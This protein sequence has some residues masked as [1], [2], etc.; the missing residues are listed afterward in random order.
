MDV[1]IDVEDENGRKLDDEEVIDV[2]LMS[3]NAGHES[4][5]HITMCATNFLQKHPEYL[6][7]LCHLKTMKKNMPLFLLYIPSSSVSV[8]ILQP[9]PARSTALPRRDDTSPL[10]HAPPATPALVFFSPS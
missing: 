9:L 7:T 5:G 1:L 8:C 4:S 3:L 10:P 2:M 6:Q